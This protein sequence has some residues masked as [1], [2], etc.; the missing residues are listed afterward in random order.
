MET[1][2][3]CRAR[4]K[5]VNRLFFISLI[6]YV[7]GSIAI[8]T[9][10]VG[11]G[12]QVIA[13]QLLI[14][15]PAIIWI[16]CNKIPVKSYLRLKRM[17]GTTVFLVLLFAILMHP[18]LTFINAVSM[19][20]L[21][22]N[23]SDTL[24]ESSGQMPFAAMFLLVAVMPACFEELVYRGVYFHTYRKH[25]LVKGALLSGFLFGL[26]HANFNQ[27][28]YAFA[29]GIFFAFL[30]EAT[31]SLFSTMLVHLCYNGFSVVVLYG[32]QYLSKHSEEFA[33]LYD[34][35]EETAGV[36]NFS[37]I[38]MLV[39]HTVVCM[40]LGFFVFRVIAKHNNRYETIFL[41]GMKKENRGTFKRLT[42]VPL[43]L[44]IL[45]LLFLMAVNELMAMGIIK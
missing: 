29:L 18:L 14:A 19:L 4:I 22:Y 33:K 16:V 3:Q 13:S 30:I 36:M 9:L 10:K 26:M 2:D 20:F 28:F 1:G 25:S 24:N 15:V 6:L 23:I 32:L 42:S 44:G 45:G 39:P 41:I 34:Q 21:E 12:V 31:G 35:A 5:S 37:D 43:I 27:F 40:A 38:A 17:D 7:F 11:L 8:G